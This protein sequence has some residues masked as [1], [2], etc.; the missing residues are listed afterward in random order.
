MKI[1]LRVVLGALLGVL[2][3]LIAF[4]VSGSL[5]VWSAW[6]LSLRM[7]YPGV[8]AYTSMLVSASCR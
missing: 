8:V 5:T 3:W 1:V 7:A 4:F 6:P 2:A